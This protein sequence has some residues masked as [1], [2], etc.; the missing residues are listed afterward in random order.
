VLKGS[1]DRR[2]A[3]VAVEDSAY[4][5]PAQHHAPRT[6]PVQ[7]GAKRF[8]R[9]FDVTFASAAVLLLSPLLIVVALLVKLTSR[10]PVFFRQERAGLNG[11]PFRIFKF[12]TMLKDNDDRAHR[13]LCETELTATAEPAPT[14]DGI[15]KLENDPRITRIGKILRRCSV[16]ELPQLFN[17]IRGQMGVVGPR[18]LPT[19]EVDLIP[20][21][22]Q[23]RS[24]VRPGL[25]GLW[26]VSGRNLLNTQQ[27]LEL[28][29]E[30]V[31]RRSWGVDL[32]ILART[33]MVLVRGDGAR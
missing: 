1:D 23:Q 22:F 7:P 21:Y 20:A 17:V 8:H 27:M 31:R 5:G 16:D 32:S 28:D 12:R 26:Q 2:H 19:W 6:L 11:R 33:P 3:A 18:P 9:L 10:G 25:T 13:E 14:S 15:F 30:Y 29:V 4:Y 24:L